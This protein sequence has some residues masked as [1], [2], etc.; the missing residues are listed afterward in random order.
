MY[1]NKI[2]ILLVGIIIFAGFVMAPFLSLDVG[3]EPKKANTLRFGWNEPFGQK[4]LDVFNPGT[5]SKALL[6]QLVYSGLV[7][8]NPD[9]A[10]INDL[11]KDWS[12]TNK[13]TV[14]TFQLKKGVK[15]HDGEDFTA[16]DVVFT[17]HYMLH[18]DVPQFHS[19]EGIKGGKQYDNTDFEK[20]MDTGEPVLGVTAIDDYTVEFTLRNPSAVFEKVIGTKTFIVPKHILKDVSPQEWLDT[21]Y[22]RGEEMLPGTGPFKFY[23]REPRQYTLLKKNKNYF[24]GEPGVEYFKLFPIPNLAT[25]YNSVIGDELDVAKLSE[26]DVESA[27]TH[28]D[29]TVVPLIRSVVGTLRFNMARHYLSY[30]E[31]RKAFLY[32]IDMPALKNSV[33]KYSGDPWTSPFKSHYATPEEFIEASEQ[34]KKHYEYNPEKAKQLLEEAAQ[35]GWDKD[36][37]IV[38]VTEAE[39][40]PLHHALESMWSQVGLNVEIRTGLRNIISKVFEKK[41]FDVLLSGQIGSLTP[42]DL[43]PWVGCN[44]EYSEGTGF[45][46][47]NYCNK[48][49]DRLFEKA[50]AT[51][52]KEERGEIYKE[53]AK[54]LKEDAAFN[55]LW[56]ERLN[57][58]VRN[59]VKNVKQISAMQYVPYYKWTLEN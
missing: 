39:E 46:C 42:Q 52:D 59:R 18:P 29:L 19:F 8:V 56:R 13:G 51:M 44:R 24:K 16:E 9:G 47:E 14:Y 50:S 5:S 7:Q 43:Y 32:A 41:D 2:S 57:F 49:V 54:K 1:K 26:E 33:L 30:P 36:H 20:Y 25:Q 28:D 38:V 4:R 12:S 23:E 35:K 31:V 37:E 53:I 45:N 10:L 17:F 6:F 27:E 58:A 11:A 40:A 55:V 22:V 15:W 48:E 34:N 21:A 3:A